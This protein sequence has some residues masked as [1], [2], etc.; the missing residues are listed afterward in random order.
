VGGAVYSRQEKKEK[1]SPKS[2]FKHRG[3]DWRRRK[4]KYLGKGLE[5]TFHWRQREKKK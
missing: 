3:V 2:K 4:G 5:K 1:G